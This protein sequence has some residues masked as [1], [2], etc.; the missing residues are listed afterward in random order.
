MEQKDLYSNLLLQRR[1]QLK[2]LLQI[3]AGNKEKYLNNYS[4]I[5]FRSLKLVFK[6]EVQYGALTAYRFVLPAENFD[7][8][9]PQNEGFCYSA[10]KTYYDQ[11][12][13]SCLPNGMLDISKCQRGEPPIV[14]SMPNFLFTPKYVQDSIE[15]MPKPDPERDE[16]QVDLE[17]RLGAVITAKRRFQ[18]N[19]AMWKGENLAIT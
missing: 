9:L 10:G 15:G 5:C 16:I 6:E 1:I 17:P 14:I 7:Y 18:I 11:Q 13:S 8:S 12:N 4:F 19:V 3:Y 2:Y